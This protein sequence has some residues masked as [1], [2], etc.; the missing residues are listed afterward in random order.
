MEQLKKEKENLADTILERMEKDQFERQIKATEARGERE[1]KR[2]N[3]S[4]RARKKDEIARLERE[5]KLQWIRE[6]L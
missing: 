4:I 3:S 6:G 5:R 1:K 2:R